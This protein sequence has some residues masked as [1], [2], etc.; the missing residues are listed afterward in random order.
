GAGWLVVP[1]RADDPPSAADY[2]ALISPSQREHWAFQPIGTFSPPTVRDAGRVRNPLD[3]FILSPLEKKGWRPNP[4]A[5]PQAL[6]RRMY[7]DLVGLPPTPEEQAA[8][9]KDPSPGAFDGL[10]DELLSRPAYG[11]RWGRHWLD[12]VRYAESNGYERDGAKPS[13]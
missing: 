9:L 12:L 11:E 5:R 3:A 13:V 8:I 2:D 6:L 7:L 10:G 4:P 1:A